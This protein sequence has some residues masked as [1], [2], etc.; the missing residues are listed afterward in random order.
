MASPTR[1]TTDAARS[2]KCTGATPVLALPAR[3]TSSV[4]AFRGGERSRETVA[5]GLS[6]WC[7]H[8]LTEAEWYVLVGGR[9]PAQAKPTPVESNLPKASRRA[10]R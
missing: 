2:L 6:R 1:P 5:D 8:Y 10:S 4:T 3:F 9:S 7:Q